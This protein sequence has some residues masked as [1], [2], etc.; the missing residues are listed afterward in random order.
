MVYSQDQQRERRR[1][2]LRVHYRGDFDLT[3]EVAAI[4]NPLAAQ[5]AA[6]PRPLVLRPKI[7]EVADA[8]HELISTVVGML[9][10]SRQLDSAAHARTVRAV[11][12]LAQR[13]TAPLITDEHIGSGRWAA[14]LVEFVAPFNGDLAAL[15]GRA[16]PPHHPKTNGL[17]ASERLEAALRVLDTPA[18]DLAFLIPK[19]ARRQSLPS[20]EEINAA[21][22]AREEAERVQRALAKVKPAKPAK[23]GKTGKAATVGA[24]R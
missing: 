10:E 2:W 14:I 4:V 3:A 15:L 8:V 9:A 20:I 7:D 18:H 5:V 6:L 12:D 13:P 11:R 22:R 24:R 21:Y 17:S 23:P 1:Q 19:A 16:L